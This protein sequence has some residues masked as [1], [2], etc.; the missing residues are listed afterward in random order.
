M[1]RR[2]L[3]FFCDTGKGITDILYPLQTNCNKNIRDP[4][5]TW[6]AFSPNVSEF[7]QRKTRTGM[8]LSGGDGLSAPRIQKR[9][10]PPLSSLF[11]LWADGFVS[12]QTRVGLA[13]EVARTA[14]RVRSG[15]GGV[16]K[17]KPTDYKS[18][19]QHWTPPELL[20]PCESSEKEVLHALKSAFQPLPPY[21][22]LENQAREQN[23]LVTLDIPLPDGYIAFLE[24]T[25][26]KCTSPQ[27]KHSQA[28]MQGARHWVQRVD[29]PENAFRRLMDGFGIS[30]MFGERCHQYIRNSNTYRGN[31]G[32][33]LDLD[34]WYE[35]PETIQKKLEADDRDADFIAKRLAE[36]Q[37]RPKP[38]FSMQEL[39]NRY[40]LLKRICSF[41]LPSASS[42]H[43][44]RPFKAR[45]VV[46]FPEPVTDQRIY[47]RFRF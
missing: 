8:Q 25:A 11:G 34:V 19:F 24:N 45:G 29:T 26:E 30:M 1:L 36:N 3:R 2:Q 21:A 35:Q 4:S 13:G 5:T 12:V 41:I 22:S 39:F 32:C 18:P 14:D 44:G 7:Y 37:K 6:R 16:M 17:W 27:T 20:Y 40:P 10:T 15:G 28:G 23:T 33:M 42:R 31:F 9:H 46:L 47:L 38:V 43:E